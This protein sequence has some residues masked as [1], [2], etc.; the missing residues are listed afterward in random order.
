M[1]NLRPILRNVYTSLCVVATRYQS[2]L[3]KWVTQT[4]C[5]FR[6][7]WMSMI[8]KYES[9]NTGN[10]HTHTHKIYM[11]KTQISIYTTYI[12]QE[13]ANARVFKNHHIFIVWRKFTTN[14]IIRLNRE[15]S[16]WILWLTIPAFM[17]VINYYQLFVSLNILTIVH[18]SQEIKS[19]CAVCKYVVEV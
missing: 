14:T 16:Y 8:I 1:E 17:P 2:S 5:L 19:R 6:V 11:N 3:S 9:G 12:K 13:R 4:G 10:T 7:L 15:E 18:I